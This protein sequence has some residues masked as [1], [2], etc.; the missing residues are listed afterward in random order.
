MRHLFLIAT[1]FLA[2]LWAGCL[3]SDMTDCHQL[4]IVRDADTHVSLKAA[5]GLSSGQHLTVNTIRVILF[6][7]DNNNNYITHRL[8]RLSGDN[9]FFTYNGGIV[10]DTWEYNTSAFLSIPTV[11]GNTE[12]FVI[13]NEEAVGLTDAL[14]ATKGRA[15]AVDYLQTLLNSPLPYTTLWTP[16]DDGR[17]P[18]F[19]MFLRG[20]F[21]VDGGHPQNNPFILNFTG[22]GF[23][24]GY[25][26]CSPFTETKYLVRPMARVTIES[27]TS[28]LRDFPPYND[29]RTDAQW[30]EA[31]RIFILGMGLTNMP[32]Q[33]VMSDIGWSPAVNNM[34]TFSFP[35]DALFQQTTPEPDIP[36][37]ERDWK[38]TIT[39]EVDAFG[40]VRETERLRN[41]RVWWNGL[42]QGV[43]SYTFQREALDDYV[44]TNNIGG[45]NAIFQTNR[46]IPNSGNF[47]AFYQNALRQPTNP[48]DF[49]PS[50]FEFDPQFI[51][52][53]D[54][55]TNNWRL[56]QEDM[57]FYIPENLLTS[58][59]T[60]LYIRAAR[61]SVPTTIE[62]FDIV[63]DRGKI[64]WNTPGGDADGWVYS[65]IG[66]GQS[67]ATLTEAQ[68]LATWGY[69]PC[70]AID[71]SGA[72]I[73]I[74]RH[75][76]DLGIYRWRTGTLSQPIEFC[77]SVYP[78]IDFQVTPA[79]RDEADTFIIPIS[80]ACPD[81]HVL[82]NTRYRFSVHATKP[83][84]DESDFIT[85]PGSGGTRRAGV[86]APFVLLRVD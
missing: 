41:S 55:T 60:A 61:A 26:G 11:S 81:N 79:D 31:S 64:T 40:T 44:R 24:S 56:L 42:G 59:A 48:N 67:T 75:F 18:A 77:S 50:T 47:I 21:M 85:P 19:P 20:S 57:T 45:G 2:L 49:L 36:Y 62:G 51:N 71:R 35:T 10:I 80:V 3:P 70:F 74:N 32:N 1:L 27:I 69:E 17:E 52:R 53:T 38:G 73:P 29:T 54:I 8:L 12:A 65:V 5:I 46:W 23:P 58:H 68:I 7:I 9:R 4:P 82:R 84:W 34:T 43:N 33:F 15:D 76:W 66:T 6:E 28:A 14:N 86:A 37:F 13:L 78:T 22:R 25:S 83:W 39:I 30:K 72:R 63:I 16:D